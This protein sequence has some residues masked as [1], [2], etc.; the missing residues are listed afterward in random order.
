MKS[1][2]IWKDAGCNSAGGYCIQVIHILSTFDK[3]EF[4]KYIQFLKENVGDALTFD[5]EPCVTAT[6]EGDRSD[7]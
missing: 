4:D 3:T 5:F 6:E 1:T 7:A 2:I